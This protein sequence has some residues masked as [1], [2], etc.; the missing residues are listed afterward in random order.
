MDV[1]RNKGKWTLFYSYFGYWRKLAYEISACEVYIIWR[2]LIAACK[3]QCK[4][5]SRRP[6]GLATLDLFTVHGAT[7]SACIR[8]SAYVRSH[9]GN[10]TVQQTLFSYASRI[11]Q[12]RNKRC[13]QDFK[14]KLSLTCQAQS[15]PKTLG[16]LTKVFSTP[17]PNLVILAWMGDDLSRRHA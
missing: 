12:R 3:I 14:I 8:E 1:E 6:D 9:V 16:I 13:K 7:L 4:S 17:G 15:T 11:F 2:K 5:P 10:R